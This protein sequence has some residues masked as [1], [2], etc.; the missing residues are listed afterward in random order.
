MIFAS[1]MLSKEIFTCL[2]DGF[3][4]SAWKSHPPKHALFS[5]VELLGRAVRR[6]VIMLIA[7]PWPQPA[8]N[9]CMKD[10][11]FVSHSGDL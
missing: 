3:I 1:S 4:L 6:P 2:R 9:V 7:V 8:R 5:D 11:V 10:G